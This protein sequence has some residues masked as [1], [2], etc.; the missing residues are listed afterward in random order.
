[1]KLI[2]R[3]TVKTNARDTLKVARLMAAGLLPAI[4]VPPYD[5]CEWRA[6]VASRQRLIRKR[7]QAHNRLQSVLHRHN[8]A[9]PAGGLFAATRGGVGSGQA[10]SSRRRLTSAIGRGSH[11]QRFSRSNTAS[12][13]SATTMARPGN[14][15]PDRWSI[16]RPQ[17][18]IVLWRFPRC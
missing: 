14:Q 18:T 17:T 12:V 6:T 15:R 5:V 8:L 3:S 7:T 16:W 13:L 1:M 11:R 4:G 9:H 2:T 10:A